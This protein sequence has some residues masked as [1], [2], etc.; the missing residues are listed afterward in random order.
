[1][2]GVVVV[3]VGVL[4]VVVDL[5]LVGVVLGAGAAR[6]V[7]VV[8]VCLCCCFLNRCRLR[9]F[10]S[11]NFV[12]RCCSVGVGFAFGVIVGVG[13][14]SGMGT[15]GG[16]GVVGLV[17]SGFVEVGDCMCSLRLMNLPLRIR[18][19]LSICLARLWCDVVVVG[20]GD[21]GDVGGGVGGCAVGV[22]VGGVAFSDMVVSFALVVV[23]EVVI[24]VVSRVV[25]LVVAVEVAAGG[26][27]AVVGDGGGIVR[28]DVVGVIVGGVVFGD[29]VVSFAFTLVAVVVVVVFAVVV[30]V[31]VVVVVAV[32]GAG[33]ENCF[34]S[35]FSSHGGSLAGGRLSS[36]W[37]AASGVG[38]SHTKSYGS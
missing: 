28:E 25:E 19:S 8:V 38:P 35:A 34:S 26:V 33:Q 3:V 23:L 7:V 22:V 10:S 36:M 18:R 29:R 14:F 12:S 5:L 6:L 31:V 11:F 17:V 1:M 27:A 32:L 4:D 21:G 20:D 15:R 16:I 37:L 9:S 13:G 30:V 24:L 2:V